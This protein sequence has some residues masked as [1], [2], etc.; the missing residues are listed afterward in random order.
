MLADFFFFTLNL[1]INVLTK[2]GG[3]PWMALYWFVNVNYIFWFP[4]TILCQFII[5]HVCGEYVSIWNMLIPFILGMLCQTIKFNI[6]VSSFQ[7]FWHCFQILEQALKDIFITEGN[8]RAVWQNKD[9]DSS[10]LEKDL[11]EQISKL[12]R[13]EKQLHK[14]LR[15]LRGVSQTK[16][17]ALEKVSLVFYI[18]KFLCLNSTINVCLH[19]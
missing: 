17:M 4:I 9:Q 8:L 2:C 18:L 11:Q 7:F 14:A 19:I 5:M 15:E 6:C 1:L 10:D 13:A 16:P 3:L 12:Q